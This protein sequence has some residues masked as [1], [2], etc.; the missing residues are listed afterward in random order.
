MVDHDHV[1]S[2]VRALLCSNCNTALGL[3][4]DSPTLMERSA[5][6]IKLWSVSDDANA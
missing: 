2:K 1:T 5:E 3:L 4:K 6:Y